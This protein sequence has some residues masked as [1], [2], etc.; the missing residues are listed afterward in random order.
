MNRRVALVTGGA[1]RLGE[2]ISRT[3]A[4]SG[5]RVVVHAHGHLEAACALAAELDGLA[6][7]ADL[8]DPKA[9]AALISEVEARCGRL[10]VLV[11]NAGIFERAPSDAVDDSSVDRHL[12]L[13]FQAPF[14]LCRSAAPMLRR[15]GRGA[16]V[17]LL[18]VST[19][20]PYAGFTHYSASKAALW[21]ATVGLAAEWA[22][23]VRVNGVAPGAALFPES[24][25]EVDREKRLSRIPQRREPGAMAIAETVLFLVEGP[26]SITGQIISVDGGRTAAF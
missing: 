3:L 25:T 24:Y 26:V 15:S 17:N 23:E 10:D 4:A 11:N 7:G 19:L 18:D 6:V 1:V 21:A 8:L 22:P 9:P 2:A 14:A 13:N 16:I 20:R 5:F 12:R